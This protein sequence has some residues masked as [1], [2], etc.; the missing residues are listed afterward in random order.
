[1]N[2]PATYETKN[3]FV[4]FFSETENSGWGGER[5]LLGVRLPGKFSEGQP[6][7]RGSRTP[8]PPSEPQDGGGEG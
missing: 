8:G 3:S 4:L 7:S 6:V 5:H 1:M 2:S